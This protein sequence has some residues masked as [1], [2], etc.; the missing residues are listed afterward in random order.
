MRYKLVHIFAKES[1]YT[2]AA[3]RA[4]IRDGIW[5]EGRQWRRAPDGHILI[6]VNGV[7]EWIEAGYQKELLSGLTV[8]SKSVSCTE[9]RG[10][11][12]RSASPPP[13]Q[14]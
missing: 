3:I 12:K 6:D 4:K 5:L 13:L 9:A 14:I 2:E 8:A 1:G 7:E 11:G 10:A